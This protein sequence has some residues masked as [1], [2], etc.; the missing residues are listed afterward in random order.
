MSQYF[1]FTLGPVQSFVAQ[2]RRTRDF[3]AGSFILSYLS[4]VAMKAVQK[5]GGTILFPAANER[6]LGWLEGP[7]GNGA[8]RPT[9]GEV[10]NRFK[11]EVEPGFDPDLVVRSVQTAWAELAELVWRRDLAEHAESRPQTREIWRRQVESFWEMVWAL[12]GNPAAS[13]VIERRK[14]WRTHRPREEAGT[15]CMLMDGY[16]ELSGEPAPDASAQ[17]EL[18]GA[19]RR[20]RGLDLREGEHL[21]AMAFIKRRFAGHF[22]RFSARLPG[23]W[24]LRGWKLP[25]AVPSV[26]YMA[27]APWLA[28]VV[29]AADESKLHR[30]QK[31]AGRLDE[32]A[33][34]RPLTCLR[35]AHRES[36]RDVAKFIRL[37]GDLFFEETLDNPRRYSDRQQAA[38]VKRTLLDLRR[39]A[40]IGPPSPFYAVLLM[41]GDSLGRQMQVVESQA[42]ISQALERF[43]RGAP[44]IVS[45]HSGFLVYAGGDDVMALL[46]LE[47]A[48]GCAQ[49]L[50]RRYLDAFEET[51]VTSTLSGAIEFAHFHVPLAR[52][53][54]GVHT[55]LDDLAKDGRG[56][57][58]V[59]ARVW[60]PGG[61][62]FEWALPWAKALEPATSAPEESAAPESEASA[63]AE[64]VA[65]EAL[66]EELRSASGQA[67]FSSNFFYRIREL[68]ELLN[69]RDES[70]SSLSPEQAVALMT[71][72]YLGSG[73]HERRPPKLETARSLVHRLLE[74]CRPVA[75]R[76][77]EDGELVPESGWTISPSLEA[78]GAL[79]ARFL[80]R[81]G[82]E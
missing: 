68:F 48:L 51:A 2:A 67:V 33:S 43:T 41:D 16:Q 24:T 35:R 74:Q 80:A 63:P 8:Q 49:A 32:A 42:P 23:G 57:D 45:E 30:F 76:F 69:P 9:Q 1:H 3:W 13:D 72:E 53:L 54:G 56:R 15:K 59:A 62:T 77:T 70:H 10:P 82:V 47:E 38:R 18:W 31:L 20:H 46:P 34:E 29:R 19:V 44:E 81:K 14:H 60:T 7:P 66:A 5:Q 61:K 75:R 71:A 4:A 65:L 6:F 25:T 37:S 79:L 27:V 78:D 40:E 36:R 52:V 55:L 50:R 39:S 73:V 21:C 17:E 58:A 26:P 64:K 11:A 28:Q 22:E 12:S